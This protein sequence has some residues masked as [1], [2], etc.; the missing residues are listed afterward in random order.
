MDGKNE[1]FHLTASKEIAGACNSMSIPR[2]KELGK[3]MIKT[4]IKVIFNIEDRM[5]NG[6]S[7]Y[8]NRITV[9]TYIGYLLCHLN[10]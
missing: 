3:K 4:T 10:I 9:F 1:R 8:H 5:L 7:A 6:S 2:R